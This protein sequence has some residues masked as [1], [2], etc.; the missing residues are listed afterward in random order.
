[1]HMCPRM[2]GYFCMLYSKEKVI[3]TATKDIVI[4]KQASNNI[5]SS[6][7]ILKNSVL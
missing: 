4:E 6:T 2:L 1:M 7:F 5:E 3:L